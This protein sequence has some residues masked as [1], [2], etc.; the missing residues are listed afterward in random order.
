MAQI[1]FQPLRKGKCQGGLIHL[2]FDVF[3]FSQIGIL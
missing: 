3:L 2:H 1:L